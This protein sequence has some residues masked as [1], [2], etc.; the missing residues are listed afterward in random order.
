MKSDTRL[1]VAIDSISE[2]RVT[3]GVYTAESGS[4]AGAQV[5]IVSK[6]GSN[7]LHG[8][9]FYAV[10]NDALDARSPFDGDTLPPFT[11]N[12]FGGSLGGPVVKNKAFFFANFE[13]LDQH[14]GHSFINFVPNAAFRAS[15]LAKSPA[16]APLVNPYPVGQVPVDGVSD[17]VT[18]V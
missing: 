4:A 2:F 6:T 18:L 5:N 14:L 8:S 3:T 16:M 9:A 7:S 10:R 13:G 17:Q 11:L 1:A 12:Q 15:V